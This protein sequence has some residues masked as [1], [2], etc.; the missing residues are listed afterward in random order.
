MTDM[1]AT[2]AC[3]RAVTGFCIALA[4]PAMRSLVSTASASSKRG[5]A[6]GF[7]QFGQSS[8]GIF[9]AALGTWLGGALIATPVGEVVGWRVVFFC[10]GVVS[11]GLGATILYLVPTPSERDARA[12]AAAQRMTVGEYWVMVKDIFAKKTFVLIIA[13]VSER[14]LQSRL[15]SA[16]RQ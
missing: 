3:R 11:V 8:G 10:F 4:I 15:S 14:F 16:A 2:N 9:A 5:A 13:Q 1:K 7:L 6:F 12:K